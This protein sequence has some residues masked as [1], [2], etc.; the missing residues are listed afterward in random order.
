MHIAKA[1]ARA[2]GVTRPWVATGL[3]MMAQAVALTL[4]AL[5]TAR[6]QDV[7]GTDT[8]R[9]AV[10]VCA[11]CHGDGGRSASGAYPS[12]AGQSAVYTVRQLKDFR[13]QQRAEA[14]QKAYMWGV[15]ALLDDET[16]QSLADYYAAQPP[17]SGHA[18]ASPKQ[19]A[20]GRKIF[21]EGLSARNVRACASCHGEKAEG[22][23]AFPRLAGQQ[24]D[25]LYRQLEGFGTKLRPHGV[26]MKEEAAGLT[27]PEKRALAVYL[28]SM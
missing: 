19:L 7:T 18:A 15:S 6:A 13:A 14:D 16:I 23:A 10:H 21:T 11:S 24:A 17:A 12:L 9:R 3:L 27:A 20:L 22:Q 26:L 5:P 1:T 4:G 28:Q 25:Y 8:A 2:R